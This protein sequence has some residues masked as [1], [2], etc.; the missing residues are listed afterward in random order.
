MYHLSRISH[1]QRIWRKDVSDVFNDPKFF[2]IP[3]ALVDQHLIPLLHQWTLNDKD[4]LAEVLGRISA[5]TTAGIVFGVGAT[6]ARLEADRKTQ[7]SLRRIAVLIT[8]AADDAFLSHIPDLMEKIVELL[9]ATTVSSPSSTTRA[10]VFLVLRALVLKTSAMHLA[11]LWPILNAE[12]QIAL[13]SVLPREQS[14]VYTNYAVLQACKLLDTLLVIAPDEF[15]L[16]EWLFITDSIDAVYRPEESQSVAL[17]DELSEELGST[18]TSHHHLRTHSRDVY[19]QKVSS[20][21]GGKRS[22]LLGVGG[23]ADAITNMGNRE[24]L[25][26]KLIKPFL[27][28]LSIYAFESTYALGVPDWEGCR[29]SL[30]RDLFDESSIV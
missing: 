23:M 22:P 29:D 20:S 11:P 9:L 24:E 10:E 27:S 25:I 12:L 17:V 8:A 5:P 15:Q 16:H 19:T 6:S 1:A 13:A 28:Q 2:S 30:L 14:E 3:F 7:L 4:R 26:A 21:T 18:T